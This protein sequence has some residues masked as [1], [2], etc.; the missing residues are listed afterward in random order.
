MLNSK[1]M[2]CMCF[3]FFYHLRTKDEHRF[4]RGGNVIEFNCTIACLPLFRLILKWT[5]AYSLAKRKRK[6]VCQ[7][8]CWNWLS[9]RLT[10]DISCRVWY[11]DWKAEARKRLD[12]HYNLDQV[13]WS[14]SS[15]SSS[16]CSSRLH[17]AVMTACCV[18]YIHSLLITSLTIM[19]AI[20]QHLLNTCK[21]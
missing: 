5:S 12:F 1:P 17:L 7:S 9:V 20:Q 21:M 3:F 6:T 13:V 16:S 18:Y 19:F 15:S 2:V 10:F 4:H 11:I 14:L 8:S